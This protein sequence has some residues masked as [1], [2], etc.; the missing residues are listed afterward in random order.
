MWRNVRG[1]R[2][3]DAPQSTRHGPLGVSGTQGWAWLSLGYFT[4]L[5]TLIRE[6]QGSKERSRVIICTD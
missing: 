5:R 3:S 1:Q 6:Q 4:L 2:I